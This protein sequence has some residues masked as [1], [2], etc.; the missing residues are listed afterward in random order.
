[1][2]SRRAQAYDDMYGQLDRPGSSRIA[3]AAEDGSDSSGRFSDS[4]DIHG[5]AAQF[6]TPD[7]AL[8][9]ASKSSFMT[10]H[11]GLPPNYKQEGL[12]GVHT[13]GMDNPGM[14]NSS[15]NGLDPPRTVKRNPTYLESP[16]ASDMESMS[17]TMTLSA[18]DML[19][20]GDS[21]LKRKSRMKSSDAAAIARLRSTNNPTMSEQDT[22]SLIHNEVE[23]VYN[24]RTAL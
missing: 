10:D 1:M 21:T 22:S 3:T 5:N 11:S 19:S 15:Y 23:V 20:Q 13:I 4:V 2:I 24:E 17:V 12:L 9:Q 16:S 7:R 8:R 18:E 6:Q 14:D